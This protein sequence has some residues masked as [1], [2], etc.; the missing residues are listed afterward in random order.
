[1]D[2]LGRL[3]GAA[4]LPAD[5]PERAG[6]KV[7]PEPLLGWFPWLCKRWVDSGFSGLDFAAWVRGQRPK[8]EV[9]VVKRSDDLQGFLV[10]PKRWIVEHTLAWLGHCRRPARDYEETTAS[11]ASFIHL[12]LIRIMLGRLA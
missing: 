2:S 1:M 10:L 6:A 3:L 5:Q 11:A 8:Q 12:A 4:V 7:R 9:E